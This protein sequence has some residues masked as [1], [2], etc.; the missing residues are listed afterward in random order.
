MRFMWRRPTC[1]PPWA[2]AGFSAL[3]AI[4]AIVIVTLHL[5]SRN[6]PDC[7]NSSIVIGTRVGRHVDGKRRIRQV[8]AALDLAQGEA[9]VQR[10]RRRLG[11]PDPQT[12]RLRADVL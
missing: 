5:V 4:V 6:G 1:K 8:D 12:A 2:R 7:R 3:R 10:R 11:A 9:D